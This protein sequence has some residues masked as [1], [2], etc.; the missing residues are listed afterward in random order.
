MHAY[1]ALPSQTLTPMVKKRASDTS[2]GRKH[3]TEF[4]L[5]LFLALRTLKQH[6]E[7]LNPLTIFEVFLVE[8]QVM[9]HV[10]ARLLMVV[11]FFWSFHK[12]NH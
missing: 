1:P 5:M 4:L 10:E 12:N 9:R 8:I 3:E 2:F 7:V 6:E 11:V